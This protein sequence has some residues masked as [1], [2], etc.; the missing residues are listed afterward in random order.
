MAVLEIGAWVWSLI[1][2]FVLGVFFG[3][4]LRDELVAD[5]GDES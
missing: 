2:A 4:V 3:I 1:G 5:E